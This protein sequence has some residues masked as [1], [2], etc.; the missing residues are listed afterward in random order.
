MLL[1]GHS[2]GAAAPRAHPRTAAPARPPRSPPNHGEIPLAPCLPVLSQGATAWEAQ[3]R[4]PRVFDRLESPTR[5]SIREEIIFSWQA[6][7]IDLLPL[8]ELPLALDRAESRAGE[9][10]KD[11]TPP[12]IAHVRHR[13]RGARLRIRRIGLATARACPSHAASRTPYAVGST[14]QRSQI[15]HLPR[16]PRIVCGDCGR[17]SHHRQRPNARSPH[18]P[19]HRRRREVVAQSASPMIAAKKARSSSFASLRP[20]P[21][22]RSLCLCASCPVPIIFLSS[23]FYVSASLRRCGDPRLSPRFPLVIRQPACHTARIR[24]RAARWAGKG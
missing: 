23:V 20:F 4:D 7:T 2:Q 24:H 10:R 6:P 17:Y 18:S 13:K 15:A 12:G 11:L 16:D 14:G 21:L 22:P 3:P 9:R 19:H 5:T 1:N 8:D